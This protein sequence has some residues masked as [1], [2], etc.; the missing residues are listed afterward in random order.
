M[1]NDCRGDYAYSIISRALW[2]RKVSADEL[3]ERVEV[4][5]LVLAQPAGVRPVL[6][7]GVPDQR[8]GEVEEVAVERPRAAQP[9]PATLGRAR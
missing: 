6:L 7:L 8:A 5:I 4:G 1:I 2:H 3:L 9:A